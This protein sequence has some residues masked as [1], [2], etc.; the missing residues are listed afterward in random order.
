MIGARIGMYC[1]TRL[2]G[3]GGM[4]AVYEALHEAIGQRA[5]VKVMSRGDGEGRY[6][7][8][9]FEEA[10]LISAVRHPGIVQIYDFN[11]LPDGTL[12]ILM[13]LLEGETLAA[14]CQ[15]LA[16]QGGLRL[17]ESLRIT[18]QLAATVAAV[19][20]RGVLHRDIKPENVMLVADADAPGGERVKLLDFGIAR[21]TDPDVDRV[22]TT[23]G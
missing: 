4:G 13:E 9:F 10:R 5:A 15:R 17:G 12:Y 20:E 21:P 19:H 23:G 2:L 7:K 8:R 18:R 1:V 16:A 22:R 6:T 11:R 14:R 3:R